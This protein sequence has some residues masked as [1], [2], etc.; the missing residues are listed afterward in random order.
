MTLGGIRTNVETMETS[1][2]GLY[3]PGGVGSH[4]VG[5]ITLVSYDGTVAA[6]NACA[7]ARSMQHPGVADDQVAAEER[8]VLSRLRARPDAGLRPAQ[9]K[10]QIRKIMW[11]KMGYIKNEQKMHEDLAELA[12]VREKLVPR[13]G[14]E[15]ISRNWNYDWIDALDVDDML[16]ICEVTIRSSVGRQESRGPFFREDFPYIDN[17]NW[18]K[19]TVATRSGNDV[20]I[21]HVPVELKYIRPQ[22]EQ[23]DFLSADY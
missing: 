16:D 22:T 14:L 7:R 19:H 20:R 11:D 15:T 17:K 12:E 10:K 21:D 6:L 3:A 9:I 13:M 8:R 23:E 18:L 5:T 1:L 2:S 4:G